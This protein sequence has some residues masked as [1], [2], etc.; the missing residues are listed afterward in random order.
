[1]VMGV[2]G[3]MGATDS[4]G[5]KDRMGGTGDLTALVIGETIVTTAM[6]GDET[7]LR[8]GG[9]PVVIASDLRRRGARTALLTQLGD[10][11]AGERIATTLRATG[12]SVRTPP[13]SGRTARRSVYMDAD[14]LT[15]DRLDDDW[16]WALDGTHIGG[17]YAHA[18]I[19]HFG[20][21]GS[22]RQPGAAG[23]AAYVDLM[24]WRSL[25]SYAPRI[26]IAHDRDRAAA[27]TRVDTHATAAD[28]VTVTVDDLAHISPEHSP[29]GY[30]PDG[31]A[32]HAMVRHWVDRWLQAGVGLVAV[33][34]HARGGELRVWA[35]FGAGSDVVADVGSHVAADVES[36][37]E[38]DV[39]S[40]SD[41]RSASIPVDS[42]LDDPT[43]S[44][45][46]RAD[47]IIARLLVA[48]HA[49]GIGGRATRDT[50]NHLDARTLTLA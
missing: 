12:M 2:T 28:I 7:E 33:I 34:D 31:D 3:A 42:V 6:H 23:V 36:G 1:M 22:A 18:D 5:A 16:V 8:Y 15:A 14:G 30:P 45:V 26:L 46:D 50:L 13:R 29:H 40:R 48:L 38:S 37:V 27:R 11:D 17:P 25:I 39:E 43:I 10:D 44:V 4:T 21:L 35:G 47:V 32:R 49:A 19:V 41:A 9:S 20:S 24:R